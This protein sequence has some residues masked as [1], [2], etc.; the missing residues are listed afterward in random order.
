MRVL[1]LTLDEVDARELLT[2]IDRSLAAC[3]C[4]LGATC[5]T[6]ASLDATRGE[7]ARMLQHRRPAAP[8]RRGVGGGWVDEAARGRS[9]PG[10]GVAGA[11][12]ALRLV[13]SAGA[14]FNL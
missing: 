14:G 6:C 1:S 11:R 10:D 3:A 8:T 5:E 13:R 9:R 7:L 12:P 4:R 2:A